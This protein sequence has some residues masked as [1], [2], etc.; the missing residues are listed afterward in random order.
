V[1]CALRLVPSYA[2][3]VLGQIGLRIGRRTSLE[4]FVEVVFSGNENKGDRPDGLIIADTSRSNW[5]ALVEVKYG[6][7]DLDGDQVGRYL[8]LAKKFDIDAVITIS[9][10]FT[11]TPKHSPVSVPGS[12]LRKADLYHLSWSS[13]RTSVELLISSGN[14]RDPEQALVLHELY[15]YLQHDSAGID[16][17]TQMNSGWREVVKTLAANGHVSKSNPAAVATAS[18]W[19]QEQRDLCLIL[20]RKIQT[21]VNLKL[22]RKHADS[23]EEWRDAIAKELVENKTLSSEFSVPD[24]ASDIRIQVLIGSR[25]FTASMTLKAR[26]DRKSTS[27]RVNWIVGQLSKTDDERIVLRIHWPG[28]RQPR[29]VR[30]AELRA[31]PDLVKSMDDGVVCNY[32]EVMLVEEI[33]GR[34]GGN[35]T[36]I[37]SIE[38]A[39]EAFYEEAGQVLKAW[40]PPAPKTVRADE[41]VDQHE[42]DKLKQIRQQAEAKKPEIPENLF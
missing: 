27:A 6:K 7:N 4:C 25:I 41:I 14:V 35:R 19:M 29:D 28:R 18:D 9:N 1:L 42:E 12:L 10:Q 24:A 20:S 33:G 13:I 11:A 8:D 32:I 40:Q 5:R 39:F 22:V 37:E 17:F 2:G 15:R 36:V 31:D 23:Q 38:A 34:F 16:G 26:S 3:E 30:L 21:P